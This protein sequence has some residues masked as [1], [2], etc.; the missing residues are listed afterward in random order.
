MNTTIATV[1][2]TP[3]GPIHLAAN[4]RG[5]THLLFNTSSERC[6]EGDGST[7]ATEILR[8]AVHQV[9][10]YFSGNRRKFDL[11]LDLQGTEFQQAVWRALLEIPFGA[12]T[13]YGAIARRISRPKAV[14]AVGAANGAN[15]I[16][17]IVPCHRVIGSDGQLT[18]YGGGLPAKRCLLIH[19]GIDLDGDR[20]RPLPGADSPSQLSLIVS[21]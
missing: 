8:D 1:D 4:A 14:R 19:E 3:V 6:P 13:S 16:S 2:N 11:P 12:T 15:P 21:S 5:L 7:A 17:I 10:E 20:I 18:G 9:T